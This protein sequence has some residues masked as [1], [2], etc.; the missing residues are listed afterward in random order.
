M[1]IAPEDMLEQLNKLAASV[2]GVRDA[3]EPVVAL[4][5][6]VLGSTL[7]TRAPRRDSSSTQRLRDVDALRTK[8]EKAKGARAALRFDELRTQL[9]DADAL[10]V[11]GADGLV[12]LLGL[13]SG[14]AQTAAPFASVCRTGGGFSSTAPIEDEEPEAKKD[15]G[16]AG[17]RA[18][19]PP[20]KTGLDVVEEERLLVRDCLYALQGIDGRYVSRDRSL[21]DTVPSVDRLVAPKLSTVDGVRE[22]CEL[23]WLYERCDRFCASTSTNEG[24]CRGALRAAVRDEL[25]D[26]YRLVAV[27]EAQLRD[28]GL[29]LRR[30]LVWLVEPLERL[31]LLAN[32]CD[33]CAPQD[34]QGGALCASLQRLATHGDDRVRDLVEGLLAKT[35]EPVLA[36]IR[37]W[38]CSGK[39]LPDPAGEFFVQETG[40][41]DDFWA[42]RFCLRPRMVPAFL[43]E[44]VASKIL[45]VGKTLTFLRRC[46]GDDRPAFASVSDEAFTYG[47]S[48][49][50]PVVEEAYER[51][52][53]RVLKAL[54]DDF[55]LL[56]HLKALESCVLL[57]QGDF[58]LQLVDG[59]DAAAQKR[60]G[61][62]G[63]S[64]ADAVAA[65]DR[66]VRNSNAC[67]LHEGAVQRLKVVVLEGDG[68][69]FGLDYDAQ[70]PIDAVVD[71]G[72]REFYARAFSAL[73]SRRRVEARLTDA[74]RSLALARRVRGLGA[75][76][77]KALRKAA[78][79]RNEMAT[80][81]A[82]VSAHVADAFAGAWKRLDQDVGKAD[83]LDAVRRA[84]RAYLDAIASDALFA[85]R[86][87]IPEEGVPPDEDLAAGALATHL[88]AVLQAAQRF[89]ALVD[90][91]VAD[92]VAGDSRAV[93]LAARLDDS[94]AHFRAAARRFTRLL[95]RASE[96]EP[97][98]TKLAFRL[99]V[100][101][102]AVE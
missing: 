20:S 90:A 31:R 56:A 63:S 53:Q 96:D 40:E 97:E 17:W 60:R 11:Q 37:R 2:M 92:A 15:W 71:A 35:S 44:D 18:G 74:W 38:V 77:R 4:C 99:E 76:E 80:L 57:A 14:D 1:A 51:T 102:Q 65:L 95:K 79:A 13:V 83:G 88:E 5:C 3:P 86:S 72:A 34:L 32:A 42:A 89:C 48:K 94:T 91:F 12:E 81:S 46:C 41:E 78:L 26:Y 36:A 68:V 49:L 69:S 52:N 85:P 75:P 98:A 10:S 16:L 25:S 70:P 73:R 8:V 93:T 61:A 66:A 22:V 9:R 23:G 67:R 28:E 7:A 87:G 55:Q 21:D 45:V 39:L 33:A 27:L 64:G 43:S 59:F 84:H 24:R 54:K 19:P 101:G 47:S 100:V 6:R 29:S 62:F 30:L 50:S 82:T 58:A